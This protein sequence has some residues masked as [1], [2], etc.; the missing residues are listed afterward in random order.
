[1]K[2]KYPVGEMTVTERE[3][4]REKE[5]K[6]SEHGRAE[7]N[8]ERR[9]RNAPS[10]FFRSTLAAYKEK[11]R[12]ESSLVSMGFDERRREDDG[13]KEGVGE[14]EARGYPPVELPD[15]PELVSGWK[16]QKST[17]Y[18][19][20]T[21]QVIQ[22]FCRAQVGREGT[23][24]AGRGSR[25]QPSASPLLPFFLRALLLDPFLPELPNYHEI[26]PSLVENVVDALNE[27][28]SWYPP[29]PEP[30]MINLSL[31]AETRGLQIAWVAND[32]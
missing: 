28:T 25:G 22:G 29:H 1:M 15:L 3:R 31:L 16:S 26:L 18:I 5:T 10:Y 4:E 7:V 20:F 2:V 32:L 13:G 23:I 12:R 27:L 8:N 24:L 6:K 14:V 30:R 17:I 9:G 11:I 19:L 21:L